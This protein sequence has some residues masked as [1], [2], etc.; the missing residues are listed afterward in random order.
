MSKK[1]KG[2][3]NIP[4]S[5]RSL[6]KRW[7]KSE[8]TCG[9]HCPVDTDEADIVDIGKEQLSEVAIE[10]YCRW[11]GLPV[12][13]ADLA[14][15]R[16]ASVGV[17]GWAQYAGPGACEQFVEPPIVPTTV[18]AREVA[19]AKA[20]R[21]QEASL[22]RRAKYFMTMAGQEL[23]M[24]MI[25]QRLARPSSKQLGSLPYVTAAAKGLSEVSQDRWIQVEPTADTGACDSVIPKAGPC[26]HIKIHP[27]AQSETGMSYEVANPETIPKLGDGACP[28]GRKEL[29]RQKA[30]PSRSPTYTS[31]CRV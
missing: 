12:G 28:S 14:Q 13:S 9:C 2:D 18:P 30:W 1:W 23:F 10:N 4:K 27:S 20:E 3:P 6:R 11:Y 16:D 26:A 25:K 5:T 17:L 21:K 15:G 22:R 29:V 8:K 31:P 24:K 19:R 7:S